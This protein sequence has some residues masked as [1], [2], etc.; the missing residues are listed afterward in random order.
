MDLSRVR[1]P[2][3]VRQTGSEK[4]PLKLRRVCVGAFR[5]NYF[6]LSF[7]TNQSSR[8]SLEEKIELHFVRLDRPF[9][10][11]RKPNVSMILV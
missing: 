1:L 9:E 6:W 2:A 8:L 4:A 10:P 5:T 3:P 11:D 7:H